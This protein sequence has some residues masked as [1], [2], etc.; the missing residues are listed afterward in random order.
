[1]PREE[2][3]LAKDKK[4]V[5]IETGAGSINGTIVLTEQAHPYRGF[6]IA[7]RYECVGSASVN[8]FVRAEIDK[9]YKTTTKEIW[10]N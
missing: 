4:I 10:G 2:A 7:T 3:A 6:V 8:A 9:L 1:L 5:V